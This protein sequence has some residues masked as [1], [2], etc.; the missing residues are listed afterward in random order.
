MQLSRDED[1]GVLSASLFHHLDKFLF[2]L[3]FPLSVTSLVLQN[4]LV[5]L[6]LATVPQKALLSQNWSP[7]TEGK[8]MT[9]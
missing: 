4:G 6:M 5:V 7:E 2:I 9:G 8:V 1:M 3:L